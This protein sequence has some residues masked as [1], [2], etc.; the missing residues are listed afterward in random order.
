MMGD[1]RGDGEGRKR[2]SI[3]G[4]RSKRFFGVENCSLTS[5]R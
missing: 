5:R 3:G 1:G 4:N 2:D